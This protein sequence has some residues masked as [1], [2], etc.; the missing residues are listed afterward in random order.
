MLT[1]LVSLLAATSAIGC[2]SGTDTESAVWTATLA[3]LSGGLIT[4]TAG[5][6]TEAGR[7]AATIQI[8]KATAGE[9]YGWRIDSGP[10]SG[11]GQIQGG[12]ALYPELTPDGSGAASANAGLPGL[13]DA[14]MLYAA[15]VFLVSTS[16]GE[17]IVACGDLAA[18]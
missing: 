4:G 6:V 18:G 9:T 12:A 1:R 2:S 3:P 13:L 10:C 17:E 14:G 8:R 5:A 16:G 7:T 15:R 11:S